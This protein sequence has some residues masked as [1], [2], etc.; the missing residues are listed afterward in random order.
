[1]KGRDISAQTCAK[2]HG[3]GI[4]RTRVLLSKFAEF[5]KA[6]PIFCPRALSPNYLPTNRHDHQANPS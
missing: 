6:V 3:T 1:L 5:L 2:Y 4:L